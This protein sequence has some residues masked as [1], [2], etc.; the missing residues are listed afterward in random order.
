MDN[1]NLMKKIAL[2][3]SI[4]I[5]NFQFFIKTSSIYDCLLNDKEIEIA[6]LTEAVDS[7]KLIYK[8]IERMN[9]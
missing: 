9:F 4:I 5:F 1:G 3:F 2:R 7:V 8:E 6:T